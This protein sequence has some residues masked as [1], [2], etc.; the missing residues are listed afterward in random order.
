MP[1][2]I[3]VQREV[4]GADQIVFSLPRPLMHGPADERIFFHPSRQPALAITERHSV[5][6]SDAPEFKTQLIRQET[7]NVSRSVDPSAFP[8]M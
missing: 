5:T 2:L 4:H 6:A 3:Q 7:P 1:V 8:S